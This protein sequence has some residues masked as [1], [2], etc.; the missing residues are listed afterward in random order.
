[1]T[2]VFRQL[3]DPTSSTYTY[4]LADAASREAILIDPVFEQATRDTA[5]LRELD[6][7]LVCTVDTHVHADHITAAW[8][9]KQTHGSRIAIAAAA[10]AT[11]A[12][13]A[14]EPGDRIEFGSRAIEARATPGHTD[15]C[16]SFVLDDRSMVFT[17]DALLIRG[18]GR[19]DFQHGSARTLYQ[20]VRRELFSLPD[21]CLVYPA[22]D[23]RGLTASSIGEERRHNPRLGGERN[24]SDFEGTMQNL[25]LAHPRQIEHAVPA[26]LVC[27]RI[28]AATAPA[29]LGWAPLQ[30]S[31]AGIDEVDPEWVATH[32]GEALV[33]DV[34]EPDEFVGPLG[35]IAGAELVPLRELVGALGAIPRDKPIV[36][37]CRSGGRSAQ[38]F[39]LLKRAGVERVAN[40]T[41]GMLRWHEYGL[42]VTHRD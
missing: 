37:V 3:Q 5:L 32:G 36:T 38:A 16:M 29:D 26:N 31:Y 15:G 11:G 30:R 42:P 10:G 17:G 25:G 1:M 13:V 7:K 21:E 8:L 19:T 9:L 41:G 27:G 12:D 14:L 39:V 40:L 35:H 4:L 23:Y 28:P 6:L 33:I 20:S 24:E 22:H 18:A 2:L 34:R